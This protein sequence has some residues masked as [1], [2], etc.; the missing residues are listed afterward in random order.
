MS[1][2]DMIGG[3][4]LIFCYFL[5]LSLRSLFFSNERQRGSGYGGE[6]RWEGIGRG[7]ERENYNQNIFVVQERNIFN[8]KW[9][10]YSVF[11]F[12]S[13]L[14]FFSIDIAL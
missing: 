14:Y 7:R 11:K 5:L 6:Q 3:F 2:F 12:Q 1:N 10:K 9:K 13:N 4:H 8:K